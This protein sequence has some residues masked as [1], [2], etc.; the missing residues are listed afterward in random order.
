VIVPE[1]LPADLGPRSPSAARDPETGLPE[2]DLRAFVEQRLQC[3]STNLYAEVVEM[4]ERYL[5]TR[6]LQETGGN[7]KQAAEMLG[8]TRGKV[9]DRIAAFEISVDKNVAIRSA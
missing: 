3:G 2:A 9:R 8:I 1:F 7:Q 5:L 4:V 6:V